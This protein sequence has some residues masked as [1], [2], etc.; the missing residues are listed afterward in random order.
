MHQHGLTLIEL[1][2]ALAILGILA[3]L[4]APSFNSLF[5]RWQTNKAISTF[6]SALFY[7]RSESVRR[8]GGLVLIRQ[9]SGEN[10]TET[11]K[12]DWRCGWILAT[13]SNK[14]TALQ[15]SN[16]AFPNIVITASATGDEVHLDRWGGMSLNN[17]SS[18]FSFELHHK[19][20]TTSDGK[21]LCIASGGIARQIAGSS[22]C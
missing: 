20:K 8:G 22:N 2:T 13:T 19:N 17:T 5:E 7:A 1:L 15:A 14:A 11:S 4:A 10:C 6:E 21:K 9:S 16:Q 12:A 18:S 3:G